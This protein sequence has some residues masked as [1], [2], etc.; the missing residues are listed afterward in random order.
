MTVIQQ[1]LMKSNRLYI[2]ERSFAILHK[3]IHKKILPNILMNMCKLRCTGTPPG[4]TGVHR[5]Q[6]RCLVLD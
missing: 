3:K 6:F 2:F 5:G 1:F 4:Q